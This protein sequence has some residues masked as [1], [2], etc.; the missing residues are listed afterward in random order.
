MKMNVGIIGGGA[1]VRPHLLAYS[2]RGDVAVTWLADISRANIQEHEKDFS[3]QSTTTDYRK[4]LDDPRVNLV[5]ICLPPHLHH[6]IGTEALRAG[7]DVLLE[8]PIAL[9]LEEADS[10]ILE[11]ERSRRRLFIA[12]NQRFLP[13]H[14]EAKRLLDAGEIGPAFLGIITC[15]G[16][17]MPRMKDPNSWKG[18]WDK[19]GGGALADTG[20][21]LVDLALYWFGRPQSVTARV[22]NPVLDVP[23]KG[24]DTGM[25][26]IRFESKAVVQICV[27]YA[28]TGD[29]WSEKKDIIGPSGSIHICSEAEKNPLW[30]V[31]NKGPS[32]CVP[33]EHDG[34]WWEFSIKKEI[35]HYLDCIR[36][37]RPE[38]VTAREAREVLRVVLACYEMSNRIKQMQCTL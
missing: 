36:N 13:A 2:S 10:L 37:D 7:K 23:G 34:A 30:I 21:H 27:T 31:K 38:A 11:A 18:T 29:V 3:I 1:V 24:D 26:L 28:A 15:I 14:R 8:K 32:Q 12:L 25:A 17:E 35:E 9:S 19:A 22:L 5:D 6:K 33:V 16:D 4:V 20:V